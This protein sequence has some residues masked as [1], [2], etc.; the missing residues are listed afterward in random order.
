MAKIAPQLPI[1]ST[2][3]PVSGPPT[4]CRCCT[5]HAIS[6]ST[7]MGIEEVLGADALRQILYKAG[8]KSAGTGEKEAECHGWKA[9]PAFRALHETPVAT[10][11]G[12]VQD[13]DIDLDEHRQRQAGTLGIRLCVRQVGRKG[14][15]YMFTGWFAGAMDQILQARGSNIHVA[16]QVYGGSEEGR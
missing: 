4:P 14:G 9:S 6:S 7:T 10:R 5:C 16:E 1:E 15:P 12:P 13:Q 11:L 8:Y 3:K 2:A